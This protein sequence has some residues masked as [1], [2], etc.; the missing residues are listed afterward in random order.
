MNANAR[1]LRIQRQT[2]KGAARKLR[3]TLPE[4]S[5][6]TSLAQVATCSDA[7]IHINCL[8]VGSGEPSQ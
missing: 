2:G 4:S 6:Q 1:R 3:A 8:F 7:G 5:R